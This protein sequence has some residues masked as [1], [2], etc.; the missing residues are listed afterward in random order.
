MVKISIREFVDHVNDNLTKDSDYPD[1]DKM[2]MEAGFH[3]IDLGFPINWS[4]I[5]DWCTM[6]VGWKHYI[7]TGTRFWFEN[8]ESVIL[9]AIRWL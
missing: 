5:H 3:Y 2:L 8:E 7:W 9:F 1:W 4:A 6:N